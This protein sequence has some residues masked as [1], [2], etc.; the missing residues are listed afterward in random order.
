MEKKYYSLSTSENN[1]FVR[2]IRIIFG[3]VCVAVAVFWIIYNIRLLKSDGMLWITI[4]FLTGFG[5]YQILSGLG[6]A[7]RF[8]EIDNSS[9]RLKKYPVLPVVMMTAQEI[10]KIELFPLSIAFFLKSK[11]RI[12]LRFGTT[13]YETNE[14]VKDEILSFAEVNNIFLEII[15]DKI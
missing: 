3:M 14:K 11:R 5:F 2:I 10:E 1:S 12:L 4:I 15:E 8:I 7:T 9:I 13:Y 6:Q